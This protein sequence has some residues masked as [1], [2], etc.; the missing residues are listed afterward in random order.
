MC[1]LGLGR[2]DRAAGLVDD[3]GGGEMN[4]FFITAGIVVTILG[5]LAIIV[6][7]AVYVA[8][9]YFGAELSLGNKEKMEENE[10]ND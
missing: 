1:Y 6:I 2:A 10:A 4:V 8:V 7:S 5:L 9:K 3:V